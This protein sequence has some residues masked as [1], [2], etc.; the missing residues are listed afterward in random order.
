MSLKIDRV[1]LEI[2]IQQDK[3]RQKMVELEDQMKKANQ[4]LRKTK[5]Q[6]G[7]N[8][9][10]Y[11]DQ[12]DV[13]KKLKQEYEDLYDEIGIAN[14]SL[15]DLGKRQKELNS[16]MRNLNPNTEMYKKLELQLQQVNSRI[17]ELK[18]TA[19]DTSFSFS[20]LAD[21]FN[22]YGTLIATGIASVTGFT[23]TMRKCVDAYAE[24]EEAQSQVIKYTGLSKDAVKELNEEFK[25][26]D[27]RTP[28]TRLNELA[29]DAGKLGISTKK[30]VMEFVQAADMINVALGEDLG[31]DAIT[32]I[33]KLAQMFGD[34]DR[35]LK[36]NMLAVGSAVNSVAQSSSASEPYLVEFTAR[37]GGVGKQAKLAVTDIMGYASAL[38]QNMLRSEM[39]STALSGLILKLYQEPA[40]YAK[41]A[42]IQVEEFTKLMAEDANEAVLVF[43]EAL[44][45]LGGMEQLAPV[46]DKMSLS[47]A[48]AASVISTLAGSVA[49]VRKEQQGANQAFVEGTSIVNEFAVQNSTVQAELDKAKQRFHDITVELG[50][51][52]LPLMKYMVTTG[53]LTVKALSLLVNILTDYKGIILALTTAVAT[54]SLSVNTAALKTKIFTTWTKAASIATG[55]LNKSIK[56]ST[57][58]AVIAGLTS[59]ISYLVLFRSE[60]K[61]T[62]E[63]VDSLRR[64]NKQVENE[65]SSQAA[66]IDRLTDTLKDNRLGL[67]LRKQALKELKSIV[68]GYNAQLTEEGLL[69]NHNTQSIEKY[70]DQLER[71]IKMKA[72]QEELEDL[73][74]RKRKND[75]EIIRLMEA[76]EKKRAELNAAQTLSD[77]NS[78]K[79]STPGAR[80]LSS[81]L[82]VNVQSL[83]SQHA[84]IQEQLQLSRHRAI[85]LTDAIQ[86]LN[87]EISGNISDV[88]FEKKTS[89]TDSLSTISQYSEVTEDKYKLLKEDF[90]KK[91]D[92]A[93]MQYNLS[94]I[95]EKQYQQK[96]YELQMQYLLKKRQLLEDDNKSTAD[97][98]KEF[99]DTVLNEVNRIYAGGISNNVNNGNVDYTPSAI[100]EDS[101]VEDNYE[102]YKFKES[103]DGQLAVLNAFHEAGLISEMEYQDKLTEITKQKEEERNNIRQTAFD[104]AMNLLS[105]VSQ[106]MTAMQDSEISAIERRYDK[107]IES[108]EKSGKDTSK[109]EEEK[110]EAVLNVKRK[111]ADKQ[112]A[113]NV[114][115]VTANTA[116][117]AM[118]AYK[119][120]SDI[121]IVGPA[122]GAA[123]AAAAVIA[124][125]AQIAV[126]K[127]QRDEAKGLYTGGY[128][129]EYVSGYTK[130]GDSR[131]VAG[132]IPVHKNEFV[133]NHKAVANPAVKQF[134][135]V[136][137]IAQKNGTIGFINTTQIL[138]QVRTKAGRYVGGYTDS[139][140]ATVSNNLV[141]GVYSSDSVKLL[142]LILSAIREGNGHLK[143][144][145]AKKLVVDVRSVRDGIKRLETLE[146]NASR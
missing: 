119:A 72:A 21:G 4:A 31:K 81:G 143:I 5:K 95:N 97:L 101:P 59:V 37:M 65:Y 87:K 132:V 9:K 53:S 51:Q 121:P 123:A 133:A 96:M 88:Q 69:I 70:L 144:I 135:D 44:N 128:S 12:V 138:E 33:G 63:S 145:A 47:G 68:P 77:I 108:A 90:E 118:G 28:R 86:M 64:I 130:K 19:V 32:Q 40:K 117:A 89:N 134:L 23:L 109:L 49:Q 55:L 38:D 120:M 79:A 74:R 76:E 99:Q 39:A 94:L 35:S 29:G 26:L 100:G 136:F 131:D 140:T 139:G 67:D 24:M 124:G 62:S 61:K 54:Y 25:N 11:Q 84:Q 112:F 13:I 102:V 7:E 48:E 43:L 36:D 141:S 107:M 50:E 75:I 57:W 18:V 115:Q 80:S 114:L 22:R 78:S 127:Q 93:G 60:N 56:F 30:D 3:A 45:R 85:E 105:S 129:K 73:Y 66:K 16:I 58:G 34:G 52:L 116:V 142:Q 6:F 27:T 20:K 82:N 10:E 83:K 14:L 113:L 1:Q 104:T 2:V 137:D 92:L 42:G 111:Y 146:R 98:D 125:A 46:L 17:K 15:R 8:S 71:Q 106:L 103:L 41:L 122:L 91:Q 126:A 110:E